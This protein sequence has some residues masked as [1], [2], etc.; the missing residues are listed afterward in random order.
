MSCERSG[1]FVA[2]GRNIPMRGAPGIVEYDR[3]DNETGRAE[4]ALQCIVRHEGA[5]HGVQP[6]GAES[7]DGS[8][9]TAGNRGA[10]YEAADSGLSVDR[11]GAGPTYACAADK[12]GS[13]ETVMIAKHV[14]KGL[15]VGG[16]QRNVPVV[17][18]ESRHA[19]PL[20]SFCTVALCSTRERDA[21]LTLLPGF[22]YAF[23]TK[24]NTHRTRRVG[25]PT[26][27]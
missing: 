14:D 24:A 8:H 22:G 23:Y 26:P 17:E 15:A 3:F 7:L 2:V 21:S 5:L 1:D 6:V 13:G 20:G 16:R 11:H 18:L 4:A 25:P 9:P 27:G 10:R 19:I 12:L